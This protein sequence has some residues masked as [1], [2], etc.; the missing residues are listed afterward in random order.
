[1]F[2]RRKRKVR[3][4]SIEERFGHIEDALNWIAAMDLPEMENLIFETPLPSHRFNAIGVGEVATS[5][6]PSAVLMAVSNAVGKPMTEYPLTPDR[7]LR[8][9]G[10]IE[11]SRKQ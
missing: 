8:A 7:I 10:K 11:D 2:K 4:R 3:V 5:P 1:M 6:G 9:L